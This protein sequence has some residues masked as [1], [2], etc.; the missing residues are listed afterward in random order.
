MFP[1]YRPAASLL[2]RVNALAERVERRLGAFVGK[3]NRVV[4]SS[5]DFRVHRRELG[6]GSALLMEQAAAQ[7]LDRVALLPDSLFA[8]GAV[9]GRIGHRMT[10]KSVRDRVDERRAVALA[11]A[12][13]GF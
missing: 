13:D 5:C 9:L 11:C 3:L 6:V 8:L 4:D 10:A 2:R 12:L 1:D 7:I